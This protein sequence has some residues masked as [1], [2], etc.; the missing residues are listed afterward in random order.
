MHHEIVPPDSEAL[1]AYRRM[2]IE[3]LRY[4]P[5]AGLNPEEQPGLLL[6]DHYVERRLAM[7]DADAEAPDGP[8]VADL[9]QA[10]AARVV[11]VGEPFAGKTTCLHRLAL[12][13]A[14][15]AGSLADLPD[16]PDAPLPVL[17]HAHRRGEPAN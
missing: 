7:L 4:L 16:S 13:C 5:F 3:Q 2:L 17:L 6:A 9:V 12:A 14:G 15:S 10:S 1:L 11:L 8:T